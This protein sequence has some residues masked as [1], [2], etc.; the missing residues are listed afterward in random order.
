M[1]KIVSIRKEYSQSR[2]SNVVDLECVYERNYLEDGT[3]CVVF[4]TY[5]PHSQNAGV[6][7]TIHVT[8]DIAKQMITILKSELGI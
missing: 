3:P 5:N 7:Q 1:G 6:S 8:K 4:K 2:R